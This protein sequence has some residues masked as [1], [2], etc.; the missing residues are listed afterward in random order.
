MDKNSL[1]GFVLIFLLL[2]GYSWYK[3]PT[4]AEIQE[5]QRLRDS[6]AQAKIIADS[7]ALL[8]EQP[9]TNPINSTQQQLPDSV[10]TQQLSGK[11][12]VFAPA[13]SGTEQELKIENDVMIVTFTN[14]GGRIK[15]VEMKEH[16]KLIKNEDGTRTKVPLQLLEDT[17]N[18]FEY[19]L[20][21]NSASTKEVFTGDLFFQ[22]EVS[23]KTV[24]FRANTSTGG[25]FE[26]VY[27]INDS[28]LMDYDVR[29]NNLGSAISR[30]EKS[31]KLNWINYLDKLEKED[32][33]EASYSSVYYKKAG[34]DPSYCS[35]RSEDEENLETPVKWVSHAQ[36]FFNTSLISKDK[37]ASAKV[38]TT[39]MFDAKEPDLKMLSANIK[40]PLTNPD[41]QTIAMQLFSGP[42]DYSML[43]SYDIDLED[44]IPFGWSIFGWVNRHVIRPMFNFLAG[45]IPNYGIVILI[46]TII[47]KTLLFPLQYKMLYSQV[48]MRVLKPELAKLKERIG[49]D[50]QK[51][52]ME[53]MK[54]YR[55]TGASP[56]SGCLPVFLQMPVWIALYRFFPAAVDFRQKG[57]LW[58]DD[59]SSY[60]EII[61]FGFSIW[62]LGSHLSLF[63]ILWIIATL[64]YTYYNSKDMDFSAQPMMKYIQYFMPLMFIFIFNSYASGLTCYLFFSS[65]IN[66]SQIIITKNF[67]INHD[68]VREEIAQHRKKP[69]KAGF[70]EKLEKAMKQQQAQQERNAK[71]EEAR[72]KRK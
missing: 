47:L 19:I 50:S 43:R 55:E 24:T 56:F 13:A 61:N 53:Q 34:K 33:Y 38:A 20:P 66:I 2:I 23:G 68:K 42:N 35:C 7:L 57:F 62:P 3:A 63:T 14:K 54:L 11:Y 51:L 46:L 17:K 70:A 5:Q 6:V 15:N 45:F 29:L 27:T 16:K 12:G 72:K 59:L 39:A 44:I 8:P 21:V 22:P 40:I 26:Q 69:K 67:I 28:Y 41:N 25:S 48:K 64:A 1:V 65:L 30:S 60:D 31:L 18:K 49:D 58:A 10:R 37:F 32:R 9:A 4:Q 71:K 36:Q 52:Q